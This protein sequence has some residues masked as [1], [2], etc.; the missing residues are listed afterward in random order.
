MNSTIRNIALAALVTATTASFAIIRLDTKPDADYIKF[1]DEFKFV[2]KVSDKGGWGSGTLVAEQ[3]VLTAA[4][5]VDGLKARDL[6]FSLNGKDYEVEEICLNDKNPWKEGESKGK[7]NDVAVLKLKDKVAGTDPAKFYGGKWDTKTLYAAEA[8]FAGFGYYGDGKTGK[9]DKDDKRRAATNA[10][11]AIDLVNPTNNE[12]IIQNTFMV[13]F[14]NGE[15]AN[16]T[17][18]KFS[19]LGANESVAAPT[20]LEGCT[21]SGDSGG[22]FFIKVGKEWHIAGVAESADSSVYGAV[23][24]FTAL[25]DNQAWVDTKVVPEPGT[26]LAVAALLAGPVLRLRR[27]RD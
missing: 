5:V 23:P 14:D 15:E 2:G 18:K 8:A 1:G 20:T 10:I 9:D 6:T 4:H 12:K 27:K 21:A 11:D 3:Y 25:R 19:P 7:G 13:D 17:M 22:G 26:M 24:F 16:N